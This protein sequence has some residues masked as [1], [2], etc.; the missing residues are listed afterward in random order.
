MMTAVQ[1]SNRF[2]MGVPGEVP[3]R[4]RY[5]FWLQTDERRLL[6]TVFGMRCVA[7]MKRHR[8]SGRILVEISNEHDPDEAWHWIRTELEYAIHDVEL[9]E[10]WVEAIKWIL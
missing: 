4:S 6:E 2:K 3:N 5:A 1:P 7:A 8:P 10:M 9:D